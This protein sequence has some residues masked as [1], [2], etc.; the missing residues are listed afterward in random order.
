[1]G[2]LQFYK[3]ADTSKTDHTARKKTSGDQKILMYQNTL[4]YSHVAKT[5]VRPHLAHVVKV[6]VV[7]SRAFMPINITFQN[8]NL[9]TGQTE[10]SR[11][12]L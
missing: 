11:V 12:I 7:Y 2:S 5:E 3:Y 9:Q 4:P 1:M 8:G 10:I 6:R